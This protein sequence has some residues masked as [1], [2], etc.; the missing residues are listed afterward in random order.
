[1][2]RRNTGMLFQHYPLFGNLR[3]ADPHRDNE[4]FS[5][6]CRW[7]RRAAYDDGGR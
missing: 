5:G 4:V 1:M 7:Y 3:V 6:W 2:R